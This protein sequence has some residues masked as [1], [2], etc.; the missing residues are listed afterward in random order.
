MSVIREHFSVTEKLMA[1]VC[2]NDHLTSFPQKGK[3]AEADFYNAEM[4]S[5]KTIAL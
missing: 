5:G 3:A 1:F 2:T 4:C